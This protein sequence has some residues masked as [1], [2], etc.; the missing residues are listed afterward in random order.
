MYYSWLDLY[1]SDGQVISGAIQKDTW[2]DI[3]IDIEKSTGKVA[4]S[5]NGSSVETSVSTG[6]LTNIASIEMSSAKACPGPDQRVL[7]IN[8][9]IISK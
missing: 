3:V 5:G 9:L 4:V 1:T 8:K 2:T 7:A 6:V